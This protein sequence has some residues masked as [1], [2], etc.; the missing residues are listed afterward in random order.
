MV[1]KKGNEANWPGILPQREYETIE[2]PHTV[3]SKFFIQLRE[4]NNTISGKAKIAD[5]PIKEAYSYW[6]TPIAIIRLIFAVVIGF[7]A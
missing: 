4:G 6:A 7:L 1:A 3:D 2:S 5:I